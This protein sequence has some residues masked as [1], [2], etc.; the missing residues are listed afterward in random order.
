MS[1]HGDYAVGKLLP[2]F[3]LRAICA[4]ER[5]GVKNFTKK[6]VRQNSRVDNT[7]AFEFVENKSKL[8]QFNT[9][10]KCIWDWTCQKKC[11]EKNEA[12]MCTDTTLALEFVV[13]E[14]KNRQIDTIPQ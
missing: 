12:T 7:L 11:L 10:P 5:T 1:L 13:V 3:F 9:F 2:Q 14:T 8:R 6:I 4:Y